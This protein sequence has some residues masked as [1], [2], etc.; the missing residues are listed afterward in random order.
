MAKIAEIQ[1]TS[2]KVSNDFA[3]N[4]YASSNASAKRGDYNSRT[5][6]DVLYRQ[7]IGN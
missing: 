6:Q 5:P 7:A 4:K 3:V 2:S 1:K